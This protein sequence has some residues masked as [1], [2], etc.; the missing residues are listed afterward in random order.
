MKKIGVLLLGVTLLVG[1]GAGDL[2]AVHAPYLS[3]RRPPALYAVF[4]ALVSGALVGFLS[5]TRSEF[6]P[7]A[8]SPA[9][10]YLL[11]RGWRRHERA[12]AVLLLAGACIAVNLQM[13][14]FF[15]GKFLD[16]YEFVARKGGHPFNAR[17]QQRT[18]SSIRSS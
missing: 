4:A 11:A 17:I 9:V 7:I 13:D 12:T 2:L 16:A 18:R 5:V 15:H 1:L 14:R 6:V 8:L 3:G 10:V